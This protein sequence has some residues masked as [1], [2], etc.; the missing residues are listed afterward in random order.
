MREAVLSDA[1]NSKSHNKEK[2]LVQL[3]SLIYYSDNEELNY[4]DYGYLSPID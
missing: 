3:I 1:G 2:L 4:D